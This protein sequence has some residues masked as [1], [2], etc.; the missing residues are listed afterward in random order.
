VALAMA[1]GGRFLFVANSQSN[2]VT[3]ITLRN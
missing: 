2:T 1:Q 3:E